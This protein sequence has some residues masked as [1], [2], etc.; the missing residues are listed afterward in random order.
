MDK[1]LNLDPSGGQLGRSEWRQSIS[2]MTD[3]CSV[4]VLIRWMDFYRAIGNTADTVGLWF[5]ERRNLAAAKQFLRK[6]FKR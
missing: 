5:S 2:V 1:A 6:A 4:P 3:C